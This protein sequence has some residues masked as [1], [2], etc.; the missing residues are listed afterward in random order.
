MPFCSIFNINRASFKCFFWT[1]EEKCG[2]DEVMNDEWDS[3]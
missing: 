2:D 3:L 1:G